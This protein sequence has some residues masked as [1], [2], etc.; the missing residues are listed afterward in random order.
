MEADILNG[1]RFVN[2]KQKRNKRQEANFLLTIHLH[3]SIFQ[4]LFLSMGT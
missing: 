1:E 2:I 3:K 4:L